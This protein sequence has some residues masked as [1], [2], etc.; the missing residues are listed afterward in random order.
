MRNRNPLIDS[1]S[2]SDDRFSRRK[3]IGKAATTAGAGI[4][5]GANLSKPLLADPIAAGR[6]AF[7][8]LLPLPSPNI[9]P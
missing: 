6:A 5:L 2:P 3:L 9:S 4:V 8:D 1:A 7:Q